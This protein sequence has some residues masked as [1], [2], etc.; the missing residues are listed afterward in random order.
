MRLDP[1]AFNGLINGLGQ[2]FTIRK[3][4]ACPCVN[5][6]SGAAKPDCPF[7]F[8]KAWQWAGGVDGRAAV[9][10]RDTLRKFV[11]FG[12]VDE[13]DM[14]ISIPSDSPIYQIGQYDR[15]VT[16]N[17]SEPFSLK[18]VRGQR[19]AMRFPVTQIERVFWIN[20]LGVIVESTPPDIDANGVLSWASNAP[21][22]G[23]TF[24]ITGR[25][26]QEYFVYQ[27]LPFDRP[28]HFG[29]ALPRKVILRRFDLLG[30]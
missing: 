16:R 4:Y 26:Q 2:H 22:M 23:V 21:P 17:R 28:M 8:G 25:R 15:V 12:S 7:C 24:S 10:S 3:A 29:S 9:V 30:R 6:N 11:D 14:M 1:I 27:E 20:Q 5:Q 19:D 18:M 13:G